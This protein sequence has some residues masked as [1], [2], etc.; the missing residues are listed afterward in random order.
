MARLN[1]CDRERSA[2][3][4]KWSTMARSEMGTETDTF[5][6]GSHLDIYS[7]LQKLLASRTSLSFSG[8][9]SSQKS[10]FVR[11]A[12]A[13]LFAVA[14]PGRRFPLRICDR[15]PSEIFT[16]SANRVCFPLSM[17]H[18]LTEGKENC[19]DF[20]TNSES[21]FVDLIF[22]GSYGGDYGG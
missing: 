3:L 12:S 16:I 8:A 10:G 6:V 2:S 4:Q 22:S 5:S 17:A 15:K 13:N 21:F 18:I 1:A 7:L 11:V 20:F 9:A 14:H 19:K